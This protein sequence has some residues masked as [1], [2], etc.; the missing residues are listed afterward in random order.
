MNTTVQYYMLGFFICL[1]MNV[2]AQEHRSGEIKLLSSP[3]PIFEIRIDKDASA[4]GYR[5]GMATVQLKEDKDLKYTY[6][7]NTN[8]PQYTA[9]ARNLAAGMYIV[10]VEDSEGNSQTEA[11]T[12]VNRI[13]HVHFDE[14]FTIYPNPS[15]GDLFLALEGEENQQ[16]AVTVFNEVG[17]VFYKASLSALKSHPIDLSNLSKGMY[18]IEAIWSDKNII[19]TKPLFIN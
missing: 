7:W 5:D 9:T 14:A 17:Q 16:I 2:R 8:P 4:K 10:T 12:I 18:Y 1:M 19:L 6:Y 3:T 13:K 15:K 11:V